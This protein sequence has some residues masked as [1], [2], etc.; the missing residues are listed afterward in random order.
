MR[1]DTAPTIQATE[2]AEYAIVRLVLSNGRK[3]EE[4]GE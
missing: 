1:V 2:E 4:G 3:Q